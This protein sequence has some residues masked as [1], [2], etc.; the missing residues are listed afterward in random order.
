MPGLLVLALLATTT[1]TPLRPYAVPPSP[2]GV[3]ESQFLRARSLADQIDVARSQGKPTAGLDPWYRDARTRFL[4]TLTRTDSTPLNEEDR[5]ALRTMR[6]VAASSLGENPAPA[7]GDA[8]ARQ[9]DCAYD[10]GALL[11]SG[12]PEALGNR[13]MACYGRAASTM[14]G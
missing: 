1:C 13:I 7:V 12:G 5:R 14:A 9:V 4:A 3:L 2:I 8:P 6:S 11:A 10:A